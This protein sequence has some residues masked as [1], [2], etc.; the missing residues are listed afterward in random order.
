MLAERRPLSGDKLLF[1][2][3]EAMVVLHQ[4]YHHRSPLRAKSQM[5]SDDLLACVFGRIYTDVEKTMIEL[6]HGAVVKDVRSAFQNAMQHKLIDAVQRLSG[7][8]VTS[9][10]SDSR[11]APDI[12]IELFRLAPRESPAVQLAE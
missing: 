12:E 4:R 2:V 3:T 9:F 1:A 10:V 7:R 5:L 6:E 8:T 11:G